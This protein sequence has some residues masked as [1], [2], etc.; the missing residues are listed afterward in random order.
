ML[1]AALYPLGAGA[2]SVNCFF[3]SLVGNSWLG[4]SVLSTLDSVLVGSVAAL[5]LTW[6]FARH[7]RALMD[8]A[9]SEPE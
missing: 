1:T 9:D 6:W 5:P 2:M 4:L 7:I 8:E 3:L